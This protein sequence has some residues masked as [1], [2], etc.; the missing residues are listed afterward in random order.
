MPID[1]D[2]MQNVNA[3]IEGWLMDDAAYL[4]FG[5]MDYQNSIG[6]SK[7]AALEIGVWR[8]KYLSLLHQTT[9]GPLFG[10]DIFK[11][12]NTE[13]EVYETFRVAFGEDHRLMLKTVSSTHLTPAG[14]SEVVERNSM[15][16]ISID[17]SHEGD[18]V[19]H[20]LILAESMLADHGVIAV[21][22]FL[23]GRA[24]GVSEGA[25][26]YFL[27]VGAGR[28]TPFACCGNK[29]FVARSADYADLHAATLHFLSENPDLDMSKTYETWRKN[30]DHWVDFALLGAKCLVL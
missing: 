27:T 16:W 15:R 3:K 1:R 28:L 13:A 8:G 5:L 14:L 20:D 24:I 17:G 4:T 6:L 19:C 26:R 23:N 22:D 30:G 7:K 11:Y 18:A 29:L 9:K 2:F 25:Y 10:L 21:D 12:G